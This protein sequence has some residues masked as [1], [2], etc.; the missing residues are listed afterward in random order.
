MVKTDFSKTN[1]LFLSFPKK[2]YNEYENLIPFYNELIELIPNDIHQ[3][4]ITSTNQIALEIKNR[5]SHKNLDTIVVR[6]WDEIWLR[7]CMGMVNGNQII[8]PIYFPNYCSVKQYWN[9]FKNLNKLTKQ[10]IQDSLSHEIVDMPIIMDGGNFI[11][12]SSLAFI[13]DKIIKDN[14]GKKVVDLLSN[15]CGLKPILVKNNTYDTIGHIDGYM[16]F[17]DEDTVFI[18]K[19]PQLKAFQKD[20]EYSEYLNKTALDN[21]LQVV[22]IYDRPFNQI[23]K[24]GCEDNCDCFYTAKGTYINFLRL[25]DTVILPEYSIPKRMDDRGYNTVNEDT[26]TENGFN[27]LKIN[28]DDV[29]KFGGALHC[30]SWQI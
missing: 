21:N 29:A 8:K 2:F 4:I 22:S 14:P 1:H 28:C 10:I 27:V 20:N 9:Y 16:S 6:N 24:C 23:A 17:K 30:L 12:N 25:N 3:F 19:Y 7:D 13:T 15:Y 5:F 18:S 11:N 26:L